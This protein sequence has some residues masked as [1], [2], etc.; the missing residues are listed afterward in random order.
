VSPGPSALERNLARLLARAYQPVLPRESFRTQLEAD[1]VSRASRLAPR[2]GERPRAPAGPLPAWRP[3]W[4]IGAG[5]A[6]ALAVVLGAWWTLRPAGEPLERVL[7]RDQVA[8]R[9]H[10]AADWRASSEPSVAFQGGFLE[11]A[12]PAGRGELVRAASDRLELDPG[13]RAVLRGPPSRA[14]VELVAGGL[15]VERGDPEEP[16][17]LSTSEGEVLVESGR[18][19]LAYA[20]L[21]PDFAPDHAP[22]FSAVRGVRIRVELGGARV[23]VADRT[24]AAGDEVL[25]AAGR[26]VEPAP[27]DPAALPGL[28]GLPRLPSAGSR[29][30]ASAPPGAAEGGGAAAGERAGPPPQLR[31]S[32]VLAPGAPGAPAA[33]RAPGAPDAAPEPCAEFQVICLR[34][35]ALPQVAE[36]QVFAFADAAGRFELGG[37]EPGTYATFVRA[38]GRA[39]WRGGMLEITAGGPGQAAHE[40]A[41]ELVPGV[42]VEGLVVDGASG[43]PV[44]GAVVVSESDAPLQILPIAE[45]ER[46]TE[47]G[48]LPL[49]RTG[50]DGGFVLEDLSSAPHVL[51]ATAPG[52]APT[53]RGPLAVV[54]AAPIEMRLE[55]GGAVEGLVS[56]D[57]G[58]PIE[59]GLL[60]L[61]ISDFGAGHPLM[62][63]A[64]AFTG[65]DG[66]YRMDDL[67]EGDWPLLSFGRAAAGM[68]LDPELAFVHVAPGEVTLRDFAAERAGVRLAGTLVGPDGQPQAGRAVW[69]IG[70]DSGQ[71]MVSTT[72]D[73]EGRYAFEGLAPR[74]YAVFL[75]R[76][77]PPDMIL[78]GDVDLRSG[79]DVL[80]QRLALGSAG[81]SGR[82]LD[83]E[84]GAP[85]A[86]AVV[87][88]LLEGLGGP[89][90]A[91]KGFT[92]KEGRFAFSLLPAGTYEVQI[93]P[94]EPFLGVERSGG[95][96]LAAAS[97][98]EL[99]DVH[100]YPGGALEV[101]VS[102]AGGGPAGGVPVELVFEDGRRYFPVD[103]EITDAE[104]RLRFPGLKAGRWSVTVGGAGFERR[105]LSVDVALGEQVAVLSVELARR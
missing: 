76:G 33:A 8:W 87:V 27:A 98:L 26:I 51:R 52:Y 61:S 2:S 68:P 17:A 55:A 85:L 6:A 43:L 15:A 37:L 105:A 40:L 90:F 28:P 73:G 77:V 64:M 91:G 46:A 10:P 47:A 25:L 54:G 97:S 59:G 13:A 74:H 95:H 81:L 50:P 100:L 9:A 78:L 92:D 42:R 20:D 96:A 89:Q 22:D 35:V 82:A 36:P 83:G 94:L 49:A 58:A 65:A 3:V 19:R 41:V 31:G 23:P 75:S 70:V 79:A 7:G 14:A 71:D 101:R 99:G 84:S 48:L 102:A 39:L 66:R 72:T 69:L 60:I 53:W 44:A 104:G 93:A 62:S 56:D 4:R 34:Q 11:L 24:L 88:L 1:F 45:P 63:Y 18:A 80:D 5:I 30:A 16:L 29:A 32:V 86:R 12:T 57:A 21:A 67:P 38:R 103:S